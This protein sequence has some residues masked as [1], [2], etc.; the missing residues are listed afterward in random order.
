VQPFGR[1][2]IP[3]ERAEF[4]AVRIGYDRPVPLRFHDCRA[5]LRQVCE[6]SRVDV[7][8][9]A[10]LDGLA[11]RDPIDPDLVLRRRS[12]QQLTLRFPAAVEHSSP[13]DAE[14]AR[15]VRVDA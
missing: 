9:H 10:V 12:G 6:L 14:P 2:L 13:E 5:E 15:I 11:L 7:E 3:Q 4:A 8:V 1:H